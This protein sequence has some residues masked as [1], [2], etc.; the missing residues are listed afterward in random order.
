MI[1]LP[2][3]FSSLP[4]EQLLFPHP[5]PIEPLSRLSAELNRSD[6]DAALSVTFWVK[7]EDCNS[8]LAFGGNKI[9]KLEYVLPDALKAGATV[10]VTT[11]GLQSNHSRQVAAAAARYGL[12]VN[13]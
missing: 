7:R 12:K 13:M 3:P 9:R 10:L 4:R 11:G 8:G 6:D 1:K 2:Y 5:S